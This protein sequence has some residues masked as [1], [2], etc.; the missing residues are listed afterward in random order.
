MEKVNFELSGIVTRISKLEQ[1]R[2]T[3]KPDLYKKVLSIETLDGQTLF[4]EI[5]NNN[6]KMLEREGVEES[7]LVK[8]TYTFQ[9]TEKGDKVYN[10]IVV[11]SITKI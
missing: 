7:S 6:L 8:I 5:R 1:I 3:V 11:S 4:V 10:N 2:R 9:G